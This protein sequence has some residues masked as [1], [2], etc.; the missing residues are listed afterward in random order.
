MSDLPIRKEGDELAVRDAAGVVWKGVVDGLLGTAG[1]MLRLPAGHTVRSGRKEAAVSWPFYNEEDA[2][3]GLTILAPWGEVSTDAST[4]EQ[5]HQ[6]F[7]A[8]VHLA[9]H[10]NPLNARTPSDI[11]ETAE[12]FAAFLAGAPA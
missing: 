3:F 1:F 8:V 4:P 6:A 7:D 9:A 12:I 11:T 10:G 2:D 5:R